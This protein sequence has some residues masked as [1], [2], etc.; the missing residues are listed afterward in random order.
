MPLP[1]PEM[2]DFIGRA[3]MTLYFT[4]CATLKAGTLIVTLR[5]PDWSA[6]RVVGVVA[7][8]AALG[9]LVN[10]PA[11]T[12]STRTRIPPYTEPSQGDERDRKAR[13]SR[14]IAHR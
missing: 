6:A 12:F 1:P 3:V 8:V 9:F 7:D 5:D 2:R 10:M 4:V 14:L 13:S 11:Q